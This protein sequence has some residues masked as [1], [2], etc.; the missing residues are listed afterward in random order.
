MSERS[1][2]EWTEAT[3][4]PVTGCTKVSPGCKHCYA[5]TFAERF[6]GVANHP[7]QQGFDL[8]LWPERLDLPLRW[9]RS[10]RILVNSMSDLF[11]EGVPEE[12]ID[13]VFDTMRRAKWHQFQ[14]LT[15]RAKRMVKYIKAR[16]K[17]W[18]PLSQSHP[19]IWLGTT[20]ETEEYMI[21]AILVAG[22]LSAVRFLSCEPLLGPLDITK[23]LDV[24]HGI[25]WVI[26][27][28]ESGRR[29]RPMAKEWVV[30]I[31]D[32]CDRAGVPFFFKQWG[33]FNK[34]KCGRL[35][36]ELTWD[37]YPEREHGGQPSLKQPQ[38]TKSL[39]RVIREAG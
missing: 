10:R 18:G 9:R 39:H 31:R 4:N 20:V 6:R 1:G 15:K 13:S 32:Q 17:Q 21:R 19:N 3:W 35:L 33:G 23:V 14:V 25:N 2:I 16:E 36:E 24:E 28:G 5:E 22:L 29:A 7:Y 34:K 8:Q 26:V 11:H 37:G 38:F 12:F 30:R 27:G